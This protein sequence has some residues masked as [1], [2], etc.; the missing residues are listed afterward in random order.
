MYIQQLSFIYHPFATYVTLY[1]KKFNEKEKA[2]KT[3]TKYKIAM[4]NVQGLLT[5]TL[6]IK[7]ECLIT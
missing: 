2:R 6:L 7:L 4:M 1:K 3:R 5:D